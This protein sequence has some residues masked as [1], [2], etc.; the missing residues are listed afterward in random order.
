MKKLTIQD[1]LTPPPSADK[2]WF[3]DRGRAFEGILHKLLSADGM[4]PEINIRP[5][6]EE[7]DGSF[8]INDRVFLLEA[9]WHKKSIIAS[10]VYSFRGKIDGKLSG[11]VGVF[12]SMS[13]YSSNAINAVSKGKELKIIFF[14]SDDVFLIEEKKISIRAAM[15]AKLRFASEYGHPFYSLRTHLAKLKLKEIGINPNHSMNFIVENEMDARTLDRL[16]ERFEF[17]Q[18]FTIIPSGSKKAIFS[19]AQNL[20]NSGHENITAIFTGNIDSTLKTKIN[21]I[22]SLGVKIITLPL[23]L[24][25]WLENY[26]STEEIHSLILASSSNGK[27]ARR[28]AKRANLEKLLLS[29]PSLMEVVKLLKGKYK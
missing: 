24:E 5:K 16:F 15:L 3:Q 23:T 8:V 13:D 19:L 12:F 10:Q 11:T 18:G 4:E 17:P 2:L 9:K 25:D 7:I 21:K 1:W 6:G 28:Y 26:V 27:M 29:T 14:T 22:K 20:S